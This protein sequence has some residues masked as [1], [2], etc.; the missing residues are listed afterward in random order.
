MPVVGQ[1]RARKWHRSGTSRRAIVTGIVAVQIICGIFFLFGI[2]QSV[3]G[4][5]RRPINWQL[6][7]L[8]ELGAALGLIIGVVMGARVLSQTMEAHD[9]MQQQLRAA[10]GAFMDVMHDRFH[11]WALTPAEWDVALFAVKGLSTAEI[12]V[13]RDTSE[14]TVKGADGGN[15]SQGGGSRAARNC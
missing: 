6:Y 10:S 5:G 13:L 15:L 11:E 12:A 2:L 1:S 14:G 4:L 8:I 9:K 7:E 3:V